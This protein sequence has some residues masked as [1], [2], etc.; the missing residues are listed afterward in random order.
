MLKE[1]RFA[2]II[3]SLNENNTLK[4]EEI[5]NILDVSMAQL[6]EI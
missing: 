2:K 3:E 1:E 4:T 5:A 6:G